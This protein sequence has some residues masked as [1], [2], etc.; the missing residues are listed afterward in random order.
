MARYYYCKDGSTVEGPIAE[1]D[2]RRMF[3]A[4]ILK[5]DTQICLEGSDNWEPISTIPSGFSQP[6]GPLPPSTRVRISYAPSAETPKTPAKQKLGCCGGI[7]AA[8]AG[9]IIFL[10]INP[11]ASYTV[12]V[13]FGL[14]LGLIILVVSAISKRR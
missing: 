7:A 12:C 3:T 13:G 2:L 5:P 9:T 11:H 4:R 8:I 10:A 1:A 14:F 6:P